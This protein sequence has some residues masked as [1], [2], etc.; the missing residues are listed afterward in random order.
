MSENHQLL[1]MVLAAKEDNSAADQLLYQYMPFIK[2]EANKFLHKIPPS[3]QD[4]GISV[5][6]CA[7]H[8]AVLAYD[9]GKGAFL[10][11]AATS[12]KHRMI[13]FSRREK[14]HA[15][16]LSLDTEGEDERPLLET[17]DGGHDNI[18]EHGERCAAKAEISEFSKTLSEYGLTLSDVADNCPKQDRTFKAC[19][20]A[21]DAARRNPQLFDALISTKKLPIARLCEYSDV[22]RKTLERH[23]RYLMAIMLAYTNGFE[24]I[25]NHLNQVY[26]VKRRSR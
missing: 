10:P 5:A 19:Q 18:S 9:Q 8:E 11:F 6:M 25:R 22:E 13:D 3:G 2:S 16:N 26:L 20:A 21:L 12:I 7:F 4:D 23:R 24:I 1:D 14:R 15:G 17:L